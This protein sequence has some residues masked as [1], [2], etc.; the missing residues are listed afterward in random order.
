MFSDLWFVFVFFFLHVRPK[1]FPA[2]A[3]RPYRD[4]YRKDIIVGRDS[5]LVVKG[6]RVTM[7]KERP[8][9]RAIVIPNRTQTPGLI[10]LKNE[11]V[12]LIR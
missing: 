7:S 9:S 2:F 3:F 4:G 12:L 11:I 8:P 6:V 10:C 5:R 1:S